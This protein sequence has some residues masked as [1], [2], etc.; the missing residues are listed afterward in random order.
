MFL[1]DYEAVHVHHLLDLLTSGRIK[2]KELPLG[3][4]ED[5]SNLAKCFKIHL[6]EPDLMVSLEDMCEKPRIKVKDIRDI[7]SLVPCE[8]LNK[9]KANESKSQDSQKV[10][11]IDDEEDTDNEVA[12]C[13]FCF[14][15]IRG[16]NKSFTNH[17]DQCQSR[18]KFIFQSLL[19]DDNRDKCKFC[20]KKIGGGKK[21]LENHEENQCRKRPTINKNDNEILNPGPEI[22]S[23]CHKNVGERNSN[24]G[25]SKS[26]KSHENRCKQ[27]YRGSFDCPKCSISL[28]GLDGLVDHY[29]EKHSGGRPLFKCTICGIRF[30]KQQALKKHILKKHK[31]VFRGISILLCN[32]NEEPPS[33]VYE[34]EL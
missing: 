7:S 24:G 23:I 16:G 1:P 15:T 22:C 17:V 2:D 31:K 28:K 6:R 20:L 8:S 33:F 12:R 32:L 21:S 13:A 3:S 29:K 5:I 9:E 10:I 18:P 25:K 34:T 27:V 11:S 14:K 30:H 26:L 4:A 19:Q